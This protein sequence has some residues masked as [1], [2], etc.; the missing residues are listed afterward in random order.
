MSGVDLDLLE[1]LVLEEVVFGMTGMA[2]K[3]GSRFWSFQNS[4]EWRKS[5]LYCLL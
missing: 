4:L 5:V 1:W 3:E 2:W